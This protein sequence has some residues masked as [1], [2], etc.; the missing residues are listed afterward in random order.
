M[1]A[2]LEKAEIPVRLRRKPNG[3]S[4]AHNGAEQ[5]AIEGGGQSGAERRLSNTE[6]SRAELARGEDVNA[7]PSGRPPKF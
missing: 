5:L 4:V 6:A 2:V 7:T 3:N 1:R